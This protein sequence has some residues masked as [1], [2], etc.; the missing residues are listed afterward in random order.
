MRKYSVQNFEIDQIIIDRIIFIV[1][2]KSCPITWNISKYHN[3]YI[4][5]LS[6]EAILKYNWI[7]IS[8]DLSYMS[9]WKN[10]NIIDLT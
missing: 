6:V 9:L 5:I 1:N 7:L 3:S 2:L 4:Q 8:P 10:W